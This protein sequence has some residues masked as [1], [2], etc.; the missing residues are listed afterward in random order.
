MGSLGRQI[1][2][3]Q[4]LQGKAWRKIDLTRDHCHQDW[5]DEQAQPGLNKQLK[6]PPLSSVRP[7]ILDEVP[8]PLQTT[9]CTG[10]AF[11][12]ILQHCTELTESRYFPGCR[13]FAWQLLCEKDPSSPA[14]QKAG[15]LNIRYFWPKP[16]HNLTSMFPLRENL[17]CI[18]MFFRNILMPKSSS[19]PQCKPKWR[20]MNY[21]TN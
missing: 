10:S 17:Q 4:G 18:E 19:D 21:G 8:R 16:S 5:L 9:G 12:L 7:Q 20:Q 6:K 13:Y 14:T 1:L 15:A 11:S 3:I 2:K